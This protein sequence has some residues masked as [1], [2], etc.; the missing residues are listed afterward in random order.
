MWW[1]LSSC[2]SFCALF[3]S[4]CILISRFAHHVVQVTGFAMHF[5]ET[6]NTVSLYMFSLSIHLVTERV[7][8]VFVLI[9]I[10][11]RQYQ[12]GP[13]VAAIFVSQ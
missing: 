9:C 13:R 2:L 7:L 10:Y 4:L 1:C 3:V 8:W 6:Q 11:A 5:V 12:G